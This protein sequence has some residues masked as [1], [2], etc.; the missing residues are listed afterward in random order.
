MR[1]ASPTCSTHA[2]GS[3]PYP[4]RSPRQRISLA[5]AARA[6]A[7]TAP[8]ASR[9]AWMSD[10]MAKRMAT[11]GRGG[12]LGRRPELF[13]DAVEDSV[14]EAAGLVGA[15][16]L[17]DLERLVDRDLRRNR[18]HPEE[19]ED[20]LAEDIA[21]HHG[22]AVEF[23]VLGVL[24]DDLVDL[25]LVELR[26]AD[27]DLGERPHFVVD[28]VAGPELRQVGLGVVLALEVQLVEELERYLASLAA[29]AHVIRPAS[30]PRVAGS[31]AR[32]LAR[33]CR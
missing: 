26:P 18:L 12:T 3:A 27:Q 14:D 5:P 25:R 21:I 1:A 11:L 13:V 2:M 28:G 20:S 19:L 30:G 4:T 16:L 10:R 6:S 32:P 15:E 22:H 24:R 9:L 8:S 7:R 29:L 31:R 23:P 17:G 33:S